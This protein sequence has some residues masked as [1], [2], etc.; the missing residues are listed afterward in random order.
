MMLNWDF[1]YL[2]NVISC[3]GHVLAS[4]TVT[5]KTL[6]LYWHVLIILLLYF[7]LRLA[8]AFGISRQE[9]VITNFSVLL[10]CLLIFLLIAWFICLII[11]FLYV[12]ISQYN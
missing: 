11:I 1:L 10:K 9:Q 6:S 5:I 8:A 3:N 12:F 2:Y 7:F 4:V